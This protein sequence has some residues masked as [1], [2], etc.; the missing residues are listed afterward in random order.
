MSR[1]LKSETLAHF[2]VST[3]FEDIP[4]EMAQKAARHLLDTVGAGLAGALA[5]ETVLLTR[6]LRLSGE[7]AGAVPLW[8]QGETMPPVS[9]AL[10]N[11]TAAH[12]FEL[13]DTGGCDHSGAVVVPAV[14]GAVAMAGRPVSGRE[15]LASVVLGYEVARRALEAC[16]A[17][18]SHNRAGFHSTGTC[19]PF[20][21]AAA[22][23]K[24]LGLT[25]GR[26]QHALGIAG[27][28]SGGTWACVH[29]GAQNKRLHAG[30]AAGGGLLSALLAREGF[31]GPNQVFE[32]VWGGFSRTFAPR[33][34]DPDAWTRD[35]GA[36][37]KL[38][39]VAIKPHASCRSTHSSIDGIEGLMAEHR[40][41]PADIASIRVIINPFVY[42]MCGRAVLHPMNEAQLSIAC[43][44]ALD[45]VFGEATLKSFS[46]SRRSDHRVEAMMRRISFVVDPA[47]HD[48]EEPFVEARLKNGAVFRT[49]VEHPLGD[50]KNPVGDERLLKKFASLSEMVLDRE[51]A[52][53]LAQKILS[54]EA[55]QDFDKEIN[56][57]LGARPVRKRCFEA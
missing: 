47:Q 13:D 23:A 43:S 12:A 56:G 15:V 5:P 53:T 26:T 55:V 51:T 35:L 32:E 34:S 42:G 6:T 24:I 29:N 7:G 54:L 30:H 45:L 27:S 2:L 3:S 14:L 49:R 40:F 44:M 16:G 25:P 37:W 22:A 4:E 38:A 36:G 50:P 31:T 48:D 33:S 21:A 41:T 1:I 52:R 20:G 10:V 57:L 19:G 28:F 46:R 17:Y 9:A 11:G 8:G 39:R 18:E